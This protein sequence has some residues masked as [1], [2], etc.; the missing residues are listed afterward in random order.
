L[1]T[2]PPT[3]FAGLLAGVPVIG[4]ANKPGKAQALAEV[5][6]AAIT[7]DL[8]EITQALQDDLPITGRTTT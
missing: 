4:Y 6:S 3:F 7:D 2:R 5:H 1:A 8:S